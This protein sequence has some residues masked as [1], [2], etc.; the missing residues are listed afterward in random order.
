MCL[1]LDFRVGKYLGMVIGQRIVLGNIPNPSLSKY[2][3]QIQNVPKNIFFF[4]EAED[5]S[6]E[7]AKRWVKTW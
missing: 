7:A 6:F 3:C 4:S 2:E 5:P 1:K